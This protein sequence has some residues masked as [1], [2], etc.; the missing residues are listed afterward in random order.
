MN[1]KLKRYTKK[2][3]IVNDVLSQIYLDRL[4]IVIINTI[5]SYYGVKTL[6]MLLNL[7]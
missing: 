4:C 7:P 3:L 5:D 1:I 2:R 6:I